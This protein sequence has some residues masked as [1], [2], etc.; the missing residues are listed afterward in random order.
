MNIH[1][2]TAIAATLILVGCETE[3]R[4]VAIRGPLRGLPGAVEQ[5]PSDTSG[6]SHDLSSA[7]DKADPAGANAPGEPVDGN[8]FRRKLADGS[9]V[10]LSRSPRQVV[11]HLAQT[12][13]NGEDDLL[14]DQVISQQLK[15]NYSKRGL[16]PHLAVDDLKR[17]AKQVYKLLNAMPLGDATP[18]ATMANIGRNM[19]EITAPGAELLDQRYTRLQVILEN[20]SFRLLL[21]R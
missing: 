21:V 2:I 14:Y 4:V 12:L 8:P 7:L 20:G 11:M 3:E 6:S 16:D 10:L 9:I 19:F 13:Q 17:D 5:G 1:T 18:G 15:D